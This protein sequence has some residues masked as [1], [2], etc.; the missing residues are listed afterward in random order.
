MY[1]VTRG[2]TPTA[3]R[4]AGAGNLLFTLAG[5]EQPSG[6]HAKVTAFSA[7]FFLFCS[8][9]NVAAFTFCDF[10]RKSFKYSVLFRFN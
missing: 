8:A 10:L 9:G 4:K 5:P 6:P 3:V 1:D 7:L 2:L